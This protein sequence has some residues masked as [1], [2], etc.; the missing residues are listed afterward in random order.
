MEYMLHN[1]LQRKDQNILNKKMQMDDRWVFRLS[2]ES[3]G[4]DSIL[5]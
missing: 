4:V 1:K 3:Y 5:K 2:I